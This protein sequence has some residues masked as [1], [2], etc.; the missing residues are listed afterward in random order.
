MWAID[1]CFN[2]GKVSDCCIYIENGRIVV[3]RL[4]EEGYQILS[5][6]TPALLT[7]VKEIASVRLPTLRGKRRAMAA[8]IPVFNTSNMDL[9]AGSLGLKGSPTKV[10]RIESP[11]VMRGGKTV[12]VTDTEPVGEAVDQLMVFLSERNLI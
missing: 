11:K 12:R 1:R 5:L 7:V 6:S 2:S 8:S 4:V 9:D 3:E 10:V